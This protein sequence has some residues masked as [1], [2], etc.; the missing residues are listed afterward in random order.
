[1]GKHLGWAS[2]HPPALIL[3]LLLLRPTSESRQTCKP[4]CSSAWGLPRVARRR[5]C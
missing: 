3:D 1:L 5:L 2:A 4:E